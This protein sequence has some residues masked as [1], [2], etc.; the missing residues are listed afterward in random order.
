M[1]IK[2][3]VNTLSKIDDA[4]AQPPSPTPQGITVE[5]LKSFLPR[6]TSVQ[7][8]QEVVDMI[9]RAEAESGVAQELI[10]EQILS[11]THLLNGRVGFKQL[12]NAIKFCNLRMMPEMT[13]EKAYKVVFPEKT[14]EIEARGQT[15][16]SFASMYNQTKTV[17]EI[18]K[19]LIVPAYVTY[20]PLYHAAIKKQFDLMNGIGAK[21]SDN[22]SPTV[23]HLAAAKLADLTKMP[24][25]SSIELK[26]GMT[27]EA[28]S[29]QQG[30][31]DQIAAFTKIQKAKLDAGESISSVQKTG[32]DV[33]SIIE[34][35]TE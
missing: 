8:N 11:Y 34:A 18:M 12:L 14:K 35:E 16:S 4:A 25:D 6:G 7:V 9:N 33:D 29:V 22:V 5:S 2:G 15:V 20:Q 13:N 28:K 24:E 23:Q 30:L 3:K 17:T 26:I 1:D 10:E 19:L 31:M 21:P 27:D 32:I